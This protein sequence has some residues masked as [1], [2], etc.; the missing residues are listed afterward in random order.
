MIQLYCYCVRP[1]SITPL[2]S[3]RYCAIAPPLMNS[4]WCDTSHRF[5]R[6]I[7]SGLSPTKNTEYLLLHRSLAWWHRCSMAFSCN[8]PTNRVEI[9]INTLAS[10][11]CRLNSWYEIPSL[12]SMI[13]VIIDNILWL[14]ANTSL[15][16]HW[17]CLKFLA[18]SERAPC[19]FSW[20]C[21]TLTWNTLLMLPRSMTV[22]FRTSVKILEAQ[23]QVF[24]DPLSRH[25]CMGNIM[26]LLT[27]L[28]PS[29]FVPAALSCASCPAFP[30]EGYTPN[31][32]VW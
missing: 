9:H 28:Y 17:L 5:C 19:T 3:R 27:P 31:A 16:I 25:R 13:C 7:G 11:K 26:N 21:P 29:D 15:V 20:S 18:S 14:P 32:W 1:S 12:P 24:L 8:L 30:W 22:V 4:C 6:S 2:V 10:S 23:C